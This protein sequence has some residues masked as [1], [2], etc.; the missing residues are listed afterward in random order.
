M[1][2]SKFRATVVVFLVGF[3][4]GVSREHA[5]IRHQEGGYTLEDLDS[6]NGTQ[7]NGYRLTPHQPY[8]LRPGDYVTLGELILFVYSK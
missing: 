8:A 3:A 7:V 2:I 1:P 6:R 5:R 4:L